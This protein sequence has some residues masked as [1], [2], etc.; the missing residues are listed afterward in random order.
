MKRLIPV[1]CAVLTLALS[2]SAQPQPPLI[3]PANAQGLTELAHYSAPAALNRA[4]FSPDSRF[5]AAVSDDTALRVWDIARSRQIAEAYEHFSF[6]KTLVWLPDTL[7]TGSWDKTAI[8][9]QVAE[10]GVPSP[11]GIIA[12]YDAVIDVLAAP[13]GPTAAAVFLG[14]GDGKVRLF[15]LTEQDITATWPVPALQVTAVAISPDARSLLTAGGYPAEG[16][17][18]WNIAALGDE[19]APAR[20]VA[21]DGTVLAAAFLN[22]EQFAIGGTDGSVALWSTS[23]DPIATLQHTDWVI[24]L[25]VSPDG[26]LLAVA[27]QDGV[28]ALWDITT[29]AQPDLVVAIVASAD[30]TLTSAAFSPDGRMLVTTDSGGAARIW[31]VGG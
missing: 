12:S 2:V 9:W 14:V 1:L 31:T 4:A 26:T 25:S 13:S 8:Q 6:V 10:N 23:G 18:L 15:N 3:T 16:V 7:I 22:A 30:H 19:S 5:L 24:D 21:Y 17:Q 29:P 28:L 27:R 20:E 11:Q